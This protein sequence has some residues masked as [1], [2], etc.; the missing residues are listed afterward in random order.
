MYYE[1]YASNEKARKRAIKRIIRDTDLVDF[2]E[3]K[4]SQNRK[5]PQEMLEDSENLCR[6]I[7]IAPIGD[8]R[9]QQEEEMRKSLL[10]F[11]AIIG[12]IIGG[13]LLLL[14]YLI[15]YI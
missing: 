15:G 10:S 9:R 2:Y 11:F 4:I 13:I 7:G 5:T 6:S 8:I 1:N 12:L 14:L 3:E